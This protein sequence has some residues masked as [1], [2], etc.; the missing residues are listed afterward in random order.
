MWKKT[1]ESIQSDSKSFA[2][3]EEERE[4]AANARCCQFTVVGRGEAWGAP[5]QWGWAGGRSCC[6]FWSTLSSWTLWKGLSWLYLPI[7]PILL[8]LLRGKEP[9]CFQTLIRGFC[10]SAKE[11]KNFTMFCFCLEMWKHSPNQKRPLGVFD[12]EPKDLI[13]ENYLT[14]LKSFAALRLKSSKV[15]IQGNQRK[16]IKGSDSFVI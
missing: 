2:L 16:K 8:P 9:R 11:A 3:E 13:K 6:S 4:V 10:E 14:C 1:P 12:L 15:Q 7:R 5:Q